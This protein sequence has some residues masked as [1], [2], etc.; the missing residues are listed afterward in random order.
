MDL[1]DT[2]RTFA[3]L[4]VRRCIITKLDVVRRRA[5]VLCAVAS[6]KINVSHL[7][8]TP[9]IGGGLIP[10]TSNRLARILLEDAPGAET[11]KGAA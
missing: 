9:F 11:L 4:G 3:E 6:A 1:E 7:A 8:L 2:I 10:A 5:S